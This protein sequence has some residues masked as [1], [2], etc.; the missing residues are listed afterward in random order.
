MRAGGPTGQHRPA[1]PP[2]ACPKLHSYWQLYDCG[3]SKLRRTCAEPDHFGRCPLP[4][5]DLRN[6]R[7]NQTAYALYLFIRDLADKDL[8]GWIDER[9][10]ELALRLGVAVDVALGC[11]D[12]TVT[13]E[14]LNIP[15]RAAGPMDQPFPGD[16]ARDCDCRRWRPARLC[17]DVFEATQQAR[18]GSAGCP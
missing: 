17:G 4:S 3:Y 14:Q 10:H 6:G 7:L 5:H 9:R 8:I 18:L 11:R 16:F 13:G 15:Q 2:P 12:R 1:C